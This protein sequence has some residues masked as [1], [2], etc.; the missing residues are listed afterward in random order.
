MLLPFFLAA[1]GVIAQNDALVR[2]FNQYMEDEKFTVV[3]VSPKMFELLGQIDSDDP[4]WNNFRDVAEDLK[5]LRVLTCDD[6][7]VDGTK[8]YK[9]AMA[10]LPPSEYQELL[11]VRDNGTNVRFMIKESAKIIEELLLLVGGPGE[12][13]MLSFTG[14][15]DLGKISKLA[16][17]VDIKGTEHLDKIKTKN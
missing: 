2:F 9:E 17:K 3:Y 15:I 7:L 11:A 4:D 13:V 1:Q 6:S 14:K 16:K 12:F 8:L 10:K 5:G